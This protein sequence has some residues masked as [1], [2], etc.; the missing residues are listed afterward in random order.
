ME[1]PECRSDV[2]AEEHTPPEDVAAQGSLSIRTARDDILDS[3]GGQLVQAGIRVPASEY[4]ASV[5][6]V[7]GFRV[8]P[9]EIMAAMTQIGVVG[10]SFDPEQIAMVIAETRGNRSHR[11]LRNS[12]EWR[13][14]GAL[15]TLRG[16]DGSPEGQRTF[17]SHVRHAA[18]KRPSDLTLLRVAI[19]TAELG[20]ALDATT[21][22]KAARRLSATIG[23]LD[24][25]ALKTAVQHETRMLRRESTRGTTRI[26][27]MRPA[28]DAPANA[29]TRRWTPGGRKNRTARKGM[30]G[31]RTG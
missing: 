15:L 23:S 27:R 3:I 9:R 8:S 2:A 22:G 16:H 28:G 6:K 12:R 31:P 26:Q 11:Q 1:I 24:A 18:G 7:A 13:A 5:R 10:H 20:L 14:L 25:D 19:A 21:I 17:L 30:R 4:V 29:S